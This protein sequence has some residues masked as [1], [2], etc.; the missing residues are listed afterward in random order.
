LAAFLKNLIANKEKV[1]TSIFKKK[2]NYNKQ[3]E[4]QNKLVEMQIQLEQMQAVFT[5][6]KQSKKPLKGLPDLQY[7]VNQL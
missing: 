1:D 5:K 6:L 7:E 3:D 4:Q 2:E